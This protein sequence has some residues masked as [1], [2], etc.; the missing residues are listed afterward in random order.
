MRKSQNGGY[1]HEIVG[2][3]RRIGHFHDPLTSW[4]R[5][6]DLSDTVIRHLS[7]TSILNVEPT[8]QPDRLDKHTGYD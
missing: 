1:L 7:D 2:L 5:L 4:D 8:P 6:S 3:K